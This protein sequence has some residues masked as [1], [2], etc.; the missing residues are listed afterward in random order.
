MK[1]DFNFTDIFENGMWRKGEFVGACGL[2]IGKNLLGDEP[3][4][5]AVLHVDSCS[6]C[7]EELKRR[8]E[9]EH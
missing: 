8:I 3:I 7:Q 2:M 1:N 9:N 6:R 5:D 4:L